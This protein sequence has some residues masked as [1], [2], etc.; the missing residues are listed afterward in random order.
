M[1]NARHSL[2]KERGMAKYP[3]EKIAYD[4][5]YEGIVSGK[6]AP[7]EPIVEQEVSN[8]LGISRTP[9]R[10]ALKQLEAQGL[11]KYIPQRGTF[12]EEIDIQDVEEIFA[13]RE[14]LELLALKEAIK[15]VPDEEISKIE[16]IL[17]ALDHNSASEDFYRS[18][19]ALH[20]L[21]VRYGGNRRLSIFLNALN[22]QVEML[23]RISAA[24]PNRLERSKKE[25]MAIVT[26]L[27]E[28]DQARASELLS[29]HIRNVKESAIRTCQAQRFV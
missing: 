24:T 19:R 28:R 1:L 15:V 29:E 7:G 22:S 8:V 26:A 2:Q 14:A 17:D 13:L 27:K 6:I 11:V 23:R 18:D 20:D 3:R 21:I 16:G 10:Q 25:H 12:A 9:V 4:Y 5:L